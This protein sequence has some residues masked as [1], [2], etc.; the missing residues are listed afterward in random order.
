VQPDAAGLWG[1]IDRSGELV[2]TPRFDSADP[3][4][5]GFAAVW[6]LHVLAYID[7]A[8]TVIWQSDWQHQ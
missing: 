2:I 6:T 7:Q 1:Y 3:F 8:G 5:A 4:S